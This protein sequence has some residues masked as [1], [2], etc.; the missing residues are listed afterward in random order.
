FG[1][2]DLDPCCT[3]ESA[4]C[5][6]YYTKEDDGLAK[7]WF[8]R[9]YMNPPYGKMIGIWMRK[10]WEE[11]QRGCLVVALV[12][13]RTDTRWWHQ[14]AKRGESRF[15]EGRLNFSNSPHPAPFPSAVVV[16]RLPTE[17]GAR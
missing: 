5:E 12:P 3:P 13:A 16:F 17:G 9:V 6:T 7:P 14:Y 1:G 2:F 11:A 4:L 8:G 15:L 10:A